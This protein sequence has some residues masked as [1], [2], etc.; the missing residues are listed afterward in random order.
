MLYKVTFKFKN[1][2]MEKAF[3]R[4]VEADNIADAI[5]K[6]MQCIL[7]YPGTEIVEIMRKGEG[8]KMKKILLTL[9]ITIVF[10]SVTSAIVIAGINFMVWFC[11]GKTLF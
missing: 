10:C 6:S 7:Y 2:Y 8:K 9:L 4:D 3:F 1:K 11:S 5:N